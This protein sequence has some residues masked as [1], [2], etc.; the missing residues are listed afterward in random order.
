MAEHN[1]RW[2][3]IATEQGFYIFRREIVSMQ[4]SDKPYSRLLMDGP[5]AMDSAQHP[6]FKLMIYMILTGED[7]DLPFLTSLDSTL[8][9]IADRGTKESDMDHSTKVGQPVPQSVAS[10]AS[11]S[12]SRQVSQIPSLVS[13]LLVSNT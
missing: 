8:V 12:D 9:P 2:G 3:M 10:G 13:S 7:N 6:V 5:I 4:N 1:V 11:S